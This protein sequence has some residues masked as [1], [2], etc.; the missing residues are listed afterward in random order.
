M[1]NINLRLILLGTIELGWHEMEATKFFLKLK[2]VFYGL[3]MI[4][5]LR[6]CCFDC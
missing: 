5:V 1:I 3:V 2:L 6:C 4:L